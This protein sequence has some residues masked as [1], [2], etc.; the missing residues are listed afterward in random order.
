MDKIVNEHDLNQSVV[1]YASDDFVALRARS[2]V[3]EA[4]ECIR[5]S[6]T[7]S[8]ILYFYVVDDEDRLVGVVPTRR[9]LTSSLAASVESIMTDSLVSIPD[10]ANLL[11]ALEFFMKSLCRIPCGL[12]QG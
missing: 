9:L 7:Q 2:S 10:N 8:A 12:P 1:Q 3:A 11:E 4:L 6:R 5:S